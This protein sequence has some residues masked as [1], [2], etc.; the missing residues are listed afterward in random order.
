MRKEK[1]TMS[2]ISTYTG[3]VIDVLNSKAEDIDIKDIAHHLSLLCRF[4]GAC[5]E[6]Y[7][8]AQHSVL[9]MHLVPNAIKLEALLHDAAEAYVGDLSAPVK[10]ALREGW[11][12]SDFDVIEGK[13]K[14]AIAKKFK[15]DIGA[16]NSQII[17]EADMIALATERRDVCTFPNNV[18][19]PCLENVKPLDG[20]LQPYTSPQVS[21]INFLYFFNQLTEKR[22]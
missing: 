19:W 18:P 20:K 9:V 2:L 6:F 4:T 7:S 15:L 3:K 17:H 5:N 22:T 12:F 14:H 11:G 21:K 8:V 13:F 16:V 10:G 1:I